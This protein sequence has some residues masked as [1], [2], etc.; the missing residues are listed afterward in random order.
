MIETGSVRPVGAAPLRSKAENHRVA[1]SNQLQG[2]RT[3]VIVAGLGGVVGSTLAPWAAQVAQDIG[4]T[5]LAMVLMPF[6]FERHKHFQA[7]LALRRLRRI[8]ESIVVVDNDEILAQLGEIP[9]LEAFATVNHRIAAAIDR[10]LASQ[11]PG[12][13]G[14]GLQKLLQLT[15]RGRYAILSIAHAASAGTAEEAV[16]HAVDAVYRGCEADRIDRVVLLLGGSDRPTAT[17]LDTSVNHVISVLGRGSL[18]LEYGLYRE[19]RNG[20]AA[21]LLAAGFTQTKF[22]RYDPLGTVLGPGALDDAPEVT[23]GVDLP[24]VPYLD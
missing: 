5:T 6:R 12:R 19:S 21:V 18:Q 7:A 9:A 22:D 13:I 17:E 15:E 2:A 14:I 10:L 1:L 11:R 20:P 3:V 16:R 23:L 24:E 8:C 4:A